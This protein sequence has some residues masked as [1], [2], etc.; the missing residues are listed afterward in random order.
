[1]V[2]VTGTKGNIVDVQILGVGEVLRLLQQKQK[3]IIIGEELGIV[4][5]GT[6]I[7]E[8]VKE[9]IIGN[10]AEKKSVDSGNFANSIEFK[11]IAKDEGRVSP[12]S[13]K[14]P[15]GQTTDKVALIL[16][17]GTSKIRPRR[18]FGNTKTRNQQKIKEII[19]D[20]IKRN[21]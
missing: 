20:E 21:I 14:Y 5:A 6:F 13:R 12:S 18:H 16:E 3:R 15:N 7:Q 10:R 19:E 11:K 1:M 2:K 4:R 17:N 8:E 9:S